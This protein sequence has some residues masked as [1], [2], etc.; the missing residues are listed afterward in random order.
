MLP[1]VIQVLCNCLIEETYIVTPGFSI[2]KPLAQENLFGI[3]TPKSISLYLVPQP[4]AMK[5]ADSIPSDAFFWTTEEQWYIGN[6]VCHQ[7]RSF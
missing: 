6:Y 3:D 1:R 5:A 7:V 2:K 4:F